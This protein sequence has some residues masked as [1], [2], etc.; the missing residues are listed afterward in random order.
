MSLIDGVTA[1]SQEPSLQ[2]RL[3]ARQARYRVSD[4]ANSSFEDVLYI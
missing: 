1:K 2:E 4:A 3:L